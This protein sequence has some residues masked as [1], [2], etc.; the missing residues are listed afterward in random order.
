MKPTFHEYYEEY[1]DRDR[2]APLRDPLAPKRLALLLRCVGNDHK[3]VLDVGSGHG[4][5]VGELSS[6]GFDSLGIEISDS[7]SSSQGIA[8]PQLASSSTPRRI[9]RGLSI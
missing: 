8:T 3:R 5:L 6:R 4:A 7:P 1:W 2:P 9:S